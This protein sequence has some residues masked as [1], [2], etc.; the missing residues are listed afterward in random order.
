MDRHKFCI[1]LINFVTFIEAQVQVLAEKLSAKPWK[2]T[3]AHKKLKLSYCLGV[4]L[5]D[6]HKFY[7]GFINFVPFI[8]VQVQ[9]LAEKLSVKTWKYT[10]I[11]KN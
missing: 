10:N 5:M 11:H 6:R 2:Y 4:Y 3:N 1:G 8:E 9:V 7:I